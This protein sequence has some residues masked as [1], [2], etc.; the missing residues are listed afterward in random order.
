MAPLSAPR[1]AGA[2]AREGGGPPASNAAGACAAMVARAK[3]KNLAP[4]PTTPRGPAA[5]W[6]C[7]ALLALPGGAQAAERMMKAPYPGNAKDPW[8]LINVELTRHAH[9][10][11]GK[12]WTWADREFLREGAQSIATCGGVMV[13]G[14]NMF[15][16]PFRPLMCYESEA[17]E[18]DGTWNVQ[19]CGGVTRYLIKKKWKTHA[20]VMQGTLG[21][22]SSTGSYDTLVSQTFDSSAWQWT[23]GSSTWA[24]V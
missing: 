12:I 5:A 7:L 10:G 19:S 1:A 22:G 16:H 4:R 9:D 6:A 8:P 23:A 21:S 3:A 20:C 17:Q 2:A 18:I 24:R 15:E 11:K 14:C 13:K